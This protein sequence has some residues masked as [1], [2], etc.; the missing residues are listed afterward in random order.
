[1]RVLCSD[2]S[3]SNTSWI[4]D[5]TSE[6]ERMNSALSVLVKAEKL[7]AEIKELEVL[8]SRRGSA[9]INRPVRLTSQVGESRG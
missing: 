4:Y 7:E 1:M 3:L 9:E 5:I 8:K 6:L 2:T